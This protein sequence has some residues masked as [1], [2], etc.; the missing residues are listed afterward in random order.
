M[1]GV[2][3]D[4]PPGKTTLKKPSLIRVKTKVAPTWN[5]VNWFPFLLQI[6]LCFNSFMTEAVII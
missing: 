2:Q 5:S 3:I 1:K 6:S 4:P